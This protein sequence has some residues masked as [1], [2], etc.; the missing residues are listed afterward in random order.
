MQIGGGA[1]S[2]RREALGVVEAELVPGGLRTRGERLAAVRLA[3]AIADG[4]HLDADAVR[5]D[6]ADLELAE[7]AALPE[8]ASYGEGELARRKAFAGQFGIALA[9]GCSMAPRRADA[10][11]RYRAC[12]ERRASRSRPRDAAARL[13]TSL[14]SRIQRSIDFGRVA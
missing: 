13:E 7:I 12:D 5:I 2:L 10:P 1:A 4:W 14:V 8:A 6:G 11:A 9:C 3:I